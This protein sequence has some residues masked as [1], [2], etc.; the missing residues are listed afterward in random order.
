MYQQQDNDDPNDN[1]RP[2]PYNLRRQR[3]PN[4]QELVENSPSDQEVKDF[5]FG[6]PNTHQR[7]GGGMVPWGQ[8]QWD[9]VPHRNHGALARVKG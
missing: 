3:R 4:M 7:G 6:R 8:V 2:Q 9:H 1:E 5:D